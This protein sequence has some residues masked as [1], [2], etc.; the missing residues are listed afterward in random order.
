MF[1]LVMF[2]L[3]FKYDDL[4]GRYNVCSMTQATL[5]WATRNGVIVLSLGRGFG[6]GGWRWGNCLGIS[7]KLLHITNVHAHT[8]HLWCTQPRASVIEI[9][10][11]INRDGNKRRYAHCMCLTPLILLLFITSLRFLLT[12]NAHSNISSLSNSTQ[13]WWIGIQI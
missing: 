5:V 2:H 10:H 8:Q 9:D 11:M 3:L 13:S 12:T 7:F 6:G 1:R 4:N